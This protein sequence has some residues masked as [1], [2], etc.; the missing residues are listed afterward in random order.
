MKTRIET[1]EKQSKVKNSLGEGLQNPAVLQIMQMVE[2]QN[3]K[4]EELQKQNEKMERTV[5][6]VKSSNE[7][8]SQGCVA[9][10]IRAD[11]F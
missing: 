7:S 1:A 10:C 9:L 11:S 2:K 3:E 8:Q 6:E 5:E 4:I